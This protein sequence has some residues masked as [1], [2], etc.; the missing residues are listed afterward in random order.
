M[1][2]GELS[3]RSGTSIETIRYY[4]REG[5]FSGSDRAQRSYRA[6]EEEHLER[7]VFIRHCRAADISLADVRALIR[8]IDF[9]EESTADRLGL[10]AEYVAKVELRMVELQTLSKQLN[11]LRDRL[12]K[13]VKK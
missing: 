3:V 13:A 5:L 11:D 7:L 9:P 2:I 10:L 8:L 4:E 6:F 12:R 1:K